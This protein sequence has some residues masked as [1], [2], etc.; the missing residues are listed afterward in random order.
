MS[1]SGGRRP[2]GWNICRGRNGQRDEGKSLKD[3]YLYPLVEE[4]RQRMGVEPLAVVALDAASGLDALGWAEQEFGDCELGD[5]RRTR[6]LVKMVRDQ[7]AQPSGSYAQAAG[8]NRYDLKGYYRFLNSARQELNLE[9]L[10]QTHRTQTIRRM[11]RESTVLIVQDTTELN[12]STRSACEGLGPIGTNQTGAQSCGLDLHSC[13]AV[14]QSGLP[15]GVLRLHGL[16]YGGDKRGARPSCWCGP[17][18][19]VAWKGP[20]RSCSSN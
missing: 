10:L 13:L 5:P 16:I 4:V 12:F 15:L 8:G 17:T 20:S 18:G 3:I 9:S 1:G 19:I 14:G 2:S 6:R 7:A 11:K